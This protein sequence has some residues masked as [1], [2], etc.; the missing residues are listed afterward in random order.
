[1]STGNLAYSW[2][3]SNRREE[4]ADINVYTTTSGTW[5]E[6]V[7]LMQPLKRSRRNPKTD[8]GYITAACT[9][10]VSSTGKEAAEGRFY[11]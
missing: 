10:T 5:D 1:M 4:R 11:R 7:E 6:F 9:A 3:R 2:S 8:P